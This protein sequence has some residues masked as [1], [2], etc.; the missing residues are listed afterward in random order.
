LVVGDG[1]DVASAVEAARS[2]DATVVVVGYTY[3]DEGE[4]IPS[5]MTMEGEGSGQALGGD[6]DSLSLSSADEELILA[7]AAANPRTVVV[8]VGGSAITMNR[9]QEQVGAILM[10]WYPGMEGGHAAARLLFGDVSPSGKLPFSIPADASQLPFFDKDADSIE[11][12]LYH[13]YTLF[14][15]DGVTPAY[16]FG[17]GLSYTEFAYGEVQGVV[18]GETV[19]LECDITNTGSCAGEEVVQCY[20]GFERSSID[21]P[22]KLLRG[23]RKVALE[24]GLTSRVSFELQA[25]D[26]AYYETARREW[27]VEPIVYTAW[28]VPSSSVVGASA[29]E[30]SFGG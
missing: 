3:E 11:Y 29:F 28:I 12:G 24:P 13:G 6:R 7:V 21:R 1:G 15:R 8:V 26:L 9:W 27:M 19:R 20:V 23:F 25:M 2:A 4:Y 18:E 10:L 14:D 5:D 16:R 22:K 30:F 17:F